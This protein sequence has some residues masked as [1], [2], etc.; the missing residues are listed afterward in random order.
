MFDSS[1]LNEYGFLGCFDTICMMM[2]ERVAVVKGIT[3]NYYSDQIH[4][5][6]E[7][8]DYSNEE[9]IEK[10]YGVS[11]YELQELS[12]ALCQQLSYRHGVTNGGVVLI[13]CGLHNV[14]EIVSILACCRLNATIVPIDERW[15]Y[16]GDRIK[17]I[18][19][20]CK[21]V[22][23][24]LV[25]NDDN[26]PVIKS[27]SNAGLFRF[28]LLNQDGYLIE[29]DGFSIELNTCDEAS[30]RHYDSNPLYI[31]YTSGSTANPKGVRGTESGLLS[32]IGWQ[33]LQYPWDREEIACQR[34]SLTFVDSL[35][36]IFSALLAGIPIW[37]PERLL[38]QETGL[39][40]IAEEANRIGVSRITLLPSQLC[41]GILVIQM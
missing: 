28:S 13:N 29:P 12:I 38:F 37:S 30:D 21:P 14:A 18:I 3:E 32:R 31:L 4:F 33:W 24:I 17:N 11:F 1:T 10:F 16:D 23:V 6:E 39:V 8:S 20:D 2:G 22:A 41:Q 15:L 26:D 5:D 27:Y 35:A 40:G 19:N 7:T 9:E 25:A 36:E 34:T